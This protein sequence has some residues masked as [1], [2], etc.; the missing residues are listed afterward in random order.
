MNKEVVIEK[1]V[2]AAPERSGDSTASSAIWAFAFILIVAVLAGVVYYSGI[3]RRA[4]SGP[5]K[6]DVKVTAPAPSQ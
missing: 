2:V 4:P 5:Q 6:I 3:L 1:Q